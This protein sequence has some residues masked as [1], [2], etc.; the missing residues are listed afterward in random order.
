MVV[1][2]FVHLDILAGSLESA[3]SE[4]LATHLRR[5]IRIC[6]HPATVAVVPTVIVHHV[7][8][9]KANLLL[10]PIRFDSILGLVFVRSVACRNPVPSPCELVA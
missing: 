8:A 10:I 7:E 5:D 9:S 3:T 4:L 2:D 1:K 6:K